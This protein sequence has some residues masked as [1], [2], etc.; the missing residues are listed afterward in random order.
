MIIFLQ[1]GI[2]LNRNDPP[3]ALMAVIVWIL[4]GKFKTPYSRALH[5]LRTTSV[6]IIFDFILVTQSY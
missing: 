1:D 5:L 3:G 6:A 2:W 4:L